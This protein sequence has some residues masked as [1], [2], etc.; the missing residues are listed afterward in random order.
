MW[1]AL[2]KRQDF[3]AKIDRKIERSLKKDD[4]LCGIRDE[5]VTDITNYTLKCVK[6]EKQSVEKIETLQRSMFG[7]VATGQRNI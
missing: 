1:S 6:L 2:K 5:V 4:K 3:V 7:N